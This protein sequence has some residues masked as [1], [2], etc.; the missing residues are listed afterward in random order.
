MKGKEIPI[1]FFGALRKG[2]GLG[3][4]K[5]ALRSEIPLSSL[6]RL[7][8][9]G[10]GCRLKTL[11]QLRKAAGLTWEQFGAMIDQYAGDE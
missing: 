2:T 7:E 6:H 8:N 9:E 4:W 10:K 11:R 5:F 1:N 3:A